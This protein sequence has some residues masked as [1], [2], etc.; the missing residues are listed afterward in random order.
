MAS[1]LRTHTHSR[2][3]MPAVGPR[4][5]HEAARASAHANPSTID[6]LLACCIEDESDLALER[7]SAPL[8][9][10]CCIQ[11]AAATRDGWRLYRHA[12]GCTPRGLQQSPR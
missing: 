4:E 5:N 12:H 7:A 10:L 1:T 2:P 8:A 6:L 11:R 9:S 3:S